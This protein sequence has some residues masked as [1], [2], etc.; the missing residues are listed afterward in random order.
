MYT[1]NSH[2]SYCGEKFIDVGQSLNC[3]KCKNISYINPLPVSVSLIKV[4]ESCTWKTPTGVLIVQ[5]AINPHK[6][7]WALPSGFIMQGET[8]QEGAAR[9]I[10]E[11]TNI[12]IAPDDIKLYDITNASNGNLL[13]FNFCKYG[14][15][16]NDIV[17]HPNDEVSQIAVASYPMELAFPTHTAYLSEYL[18]IMQ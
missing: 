1:K 10:L 17:F 4:R 3:K 5:R 7:K 6:N 9:E 2:C 8:W 16:I 13:I 12:Q 14:I 18:S 11:E 15:S